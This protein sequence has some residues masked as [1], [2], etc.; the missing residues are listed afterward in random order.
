MDVPDPLTPVERLLALAGLYTQHHD[1]IDVLLAGRARPDT[2]AYV[3]CARHL[4]REAHAGVKPVRQQRLPA[5]EPVTSALVRLRQIAYLTGGAT[6]Y[7]A[8]AQQTLPTQD[9]EHTHP[10]R[11]RGFGPYVR[12]ARELTELAPLAIVEAALHIAARLPGHARGTTPVAGIDAAQRNALLEVARGHV[13]VSE[14]G[15]RVYG[16]T[17]TVDNELMR[18]LEAQQLVHRTIGS[19]PPAFPGG[20]VRDRACLTAIGV[21]TLSTVLNTPLYSGLSAARPAAAV[22]PTAAPATRAHR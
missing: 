7:L 3:A 10:D 12:L 17:I 19:A 4:E 21:S 1:R 8:T 2:D 15:Q 22:F 13:T 11:H 9:A 18:H 6:R 5:I 14:Q 16:H 20:P